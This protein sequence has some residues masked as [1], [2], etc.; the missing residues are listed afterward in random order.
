MNL[1][2]T[3]AARPSNSGCSHDVHS[4]TP[5]SEIGLN[6]TH[7]DQT[8]WHGNDNTAPRM[9]YWIAVVLAVALVTAAGTV[10]PA[11]AKGTFE[12]PPSKAGMKPEIRRIPTMTV[13]FV[14]GTRPTM[15]AKGCGPAWAKLMAWAEMNRLLHKDTVYAGISNGD[16]STTM[17]EKECY[18]AC[19]SVPQETKG[20]GNV[21]IGAVGGRDYSVFL[22]HG[23][24]ENLKQ[25]YAIIYKTW[26]HNTELKIG[27][28][29]ALEIYKTPSRD[30]PP[31][32]LLT[33]VC[34]PLAE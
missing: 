11:K 30:T 3:R 27:T 13:A 18:D 32:E 31:E 14:P 29:P 12:K 33:E 19:I 16:P 1:S 34:V 26:A 25:T 2:G 20:D 21:V 22:H 9:S 4:D 23:P 7:S 15:D 17:R 10:V 8:D 5:F 6:T 24:W 28:G